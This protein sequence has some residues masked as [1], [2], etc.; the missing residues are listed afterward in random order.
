M[1]S[2]SKLCIL[3]VSLAAVTSAFTSTKQVKRKQT[4]RNLFFFGILDSGKNEAKEKDS[5]KKND[6]KSPSN[7][8]ST[9]STMES[10][11]KSQELGKKT[12]G[13]FEDNYF[14]YLKLKRLCLKYSYVLNHH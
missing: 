6:N 9:A 2:L 5:Q 8:G 3:V 10:F 1:F 4:H 12:A 11:K 14:C 7:M 13:R